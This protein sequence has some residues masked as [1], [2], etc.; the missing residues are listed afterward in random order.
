MPKLPAPA[1]DNALISPPGSM[2]QCFQFV[3]NRSHLRCGQLWIHRQGEELLGAPFG[4]GKR[5]LSVSEKT[6]CLLQMNRNGVMNAAGNSSARHR[7]Q[8]PIA[9][10]HAHQLK[11]V[12]ET[13]LLSPP[14]Q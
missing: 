11:G 14:G 3:D 12:N 9:L 4:D 1:S 13:S 7:L 2:Q 5:P 6:I 10:L 8:N